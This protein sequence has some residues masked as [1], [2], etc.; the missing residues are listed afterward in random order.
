MTQP[1]KIVFAPGCLEQMEQEMTFEDLQQFMDEL[2]QK[3]ENG[4]F[5]EEEHPLDL[6]QLKVED[7]EMHASLTARLE[8]IDIDNIQPP[9]LS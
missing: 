8:E 3:L 4:T 6:D 2:R 1:L 7:P 5:F 9:V